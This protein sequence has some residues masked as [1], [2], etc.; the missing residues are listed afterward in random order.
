MLA[1]ATRRRADMQSPSGADAEPPPAAEW[2]AV[3]RHLPRARVVVDVLPSASHL[4]PLEA[5]DAVADAL[6]SLL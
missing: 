5:P 1:T 3:L 6:A 2:R 4:I